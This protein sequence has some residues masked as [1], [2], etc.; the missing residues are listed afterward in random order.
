MSWTSTPEF[1]TTGYE[2]TDHRL[3]V[4]I[5]KCKAD[6]EAAIGA[7]KV[8][9]QPVQTI[10]RQDANAYRDSP[11]ASDGTKLRRKI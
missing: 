1:K 6:L 3:K 2:A 5:A 9:Q 11:N 4:R 7:F 8:Y 10:T